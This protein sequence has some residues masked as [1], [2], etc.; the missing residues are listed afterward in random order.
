MNTAQGSGESASKPMLIVDR[1][2]PLL[3]MERATRD[4]LD[5]WGPGCTVVTISGSAKSVA[6]NAE[7]VELGKVAGWRGRLASIHPLRD[8]LN[9]AT[10]GRPIIAVGIWSFVAAAI[11]SLGTGRRIVVWEHSLLPWRL[12]H[13]KSIVLGAILLRLFASRCSRV[14]SVSVASQ[15]C[16][17]PLVWPFASVEVI[18]NITPLRTKAASPD[19]TSSTEEVRLLGIGSLSRRKNWSLAIEAMHYLPTRY[20]LRIAG[21]GPDKARLTRLIERTGLSSRV[22]LMGYVPN[23]SHLLAEADVL[24]HPSKA[25]TFGY[26]L[27]EAADSDTAVAAIDRP[28]MNEFI[29]V[30]VPGSAGGQTARKFASSIS[31]AADTTREAFDASRKLRTSTL[32]QG[33][34][35]ARWSEVLSIRDTE[36][37]LRR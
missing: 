19:I 5:A 8:Q 30:L 37:S 4:L 21:D 35:L 11:A 26:V 10:S 32:D 25:E 36:G 18:E 27:F 34:I 3:G 24:V 1:L 16:A 15:R 23:A 28:V 20:R 14:I 7:V 12:G 2:E 33:T 22:E 13:E 31:R 29:P 6:H 9:R 17:I